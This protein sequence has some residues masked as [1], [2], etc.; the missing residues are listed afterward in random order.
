M[1]YTYKSC[2]NIPALAPCTDR[3]W[4]QP[5]V[6]MVTEWDVEVWSNS[7]SAQCNLK[8]KDYQLKL[9]T[10]ILHAALRPSSNLFSFAETQ[11]W[12]YSAKFWPNPPQLLALHK[13]MHT[14]KCLGKGYSV[15]P[16][17]PLMLLCTIHP[18]SIS[19]FFMAKPKKFFL[20]DLA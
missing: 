8:N 14:Y 7:V 15:P 19:V 4:C 6:S 5:I 18:R 20:H 2:V 9:T 10:V 3:V 17:W 11:F 16:D 12:P 1:A 13:H